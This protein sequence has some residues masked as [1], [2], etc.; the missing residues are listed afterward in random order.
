MSALYESSFERR[1]LFGRFPFS[2]G[3]LPS[4]LDSAA[5]TNFAALWELHPVTAI[6]FAKQ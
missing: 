3:R 5:R 4:E 1:T 6:E 2:S